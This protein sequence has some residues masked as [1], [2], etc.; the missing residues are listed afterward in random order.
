MNLAPVCPGEF[1]DEI[2]RLC[3]I[4][5]VNEGEAEALAKQR[6][7]SVE[8][9]KAALGILLA[10][11]A[12]AAVI[13]LGASGAVFSYDGVMEHVPISTATAVDTTVRA[14]RR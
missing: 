12:R 3:D 5:C 9:A 13:T 2:I 10:L 1:D 4:L 6:V 11:G 14:C 8:E 7:T